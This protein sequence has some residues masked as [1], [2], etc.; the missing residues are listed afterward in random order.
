M[1]VSIVCVYNN[2]KILKN[3]LLEGLKKQN[4]EYELILINNVQNKF[5]SA[6]KALNHGASKA[7]GK[8]IVFAHQDIKFKHENVLANIYNCIKNHPEGIFGIAGRDDSNI[9]LSNIEHG[10]PPQRINDIQIKGL[11]PVQT[12][13]ECLFIV[14]KKIFEQ[15]KFD[16]KTIDNWHLYAVDYCLEAQ[17]KGIKSYVIG[18]NGIIHRSSGYSM[19]NNYYKTLRKVAKKHKNIPIIYTTMGKWP[20]NKILLEIFILLKKAKK[21]LNKTILK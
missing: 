11:I 6:A 18:I 9:T 12:L 20:T 3:Y 2:E 19:N 1:L 10:I 4:F 13:D 16:E 7:K 21:I 17:E 8:Y 5:S 15:Q 14:P